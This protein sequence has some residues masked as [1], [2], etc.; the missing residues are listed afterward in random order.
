MLVLR[1]RSNWKTELPFLHVYKPGVAKVSPELR[2]RARIALEV[3][4]SIQELGNPL[5]DGNCVR[6][7]G[8]PA[9][10]LQTHQEPG[11]KLGY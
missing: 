5:H 6:I 3:T 4:R 8:Q 10:I 9:A 1:P 2:T 11:E 7:G